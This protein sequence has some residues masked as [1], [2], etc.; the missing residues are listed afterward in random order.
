MSIDRRAF[1]GLAIAA[2][3]STVGCQSLHAAP[4]T[5]STANANPAIQEI[6]FYSDSYKPTERERSEEASR[7][8]INLPRDVEEG[9]STWHFP[10][11]A[12]VG[13][14]YKKPGSMWASGYHT[15][16]DFAVDKGTEIQAI[17][18]GVVLSS[19]WGGPYGNQVVIQHP[20]NRYSQYAHFSAL[21]VRAGSR[22]KGGQVIGLSGATGNVTGPH[23]HFEVRTGPS[24]GSDIDPIKFLKSRNAK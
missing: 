4:I 12:P 3:A 7:R 8:S 19:G 6:N 21:H 10:V 15:G 20:D 23:L 17:G 13:T 5:N 16:A 1:L 2:G 18:P 11:D 14:P 22:V 9:D 24:Y